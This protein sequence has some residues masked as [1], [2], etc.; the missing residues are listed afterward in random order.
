[1]FILRSQE[2]ITKAIESARTLHPKVSVV[3]FGE[4]RVTGSKGKGYTVRCWRDSQNRKVVDCSCPTRDGVACKHAA[5]AIAQ[6][7]YIASQQSH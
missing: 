3:R 1:M 2:Q 6:H 4:Y 5:A 7:I